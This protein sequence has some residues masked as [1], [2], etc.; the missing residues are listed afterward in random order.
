[1]QVLSEIVIRRLQLFDNVSGS[2]ASSLERHV[3]MSLIHVVNVVLVLHGL[4]VVLI[5]EDFC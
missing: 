5:L 4:P 3:A 2:T 1:M